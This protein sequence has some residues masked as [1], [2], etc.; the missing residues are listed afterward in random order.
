MASARD[1]IINKEHHDS[2]CGVSWAPCEVLSCRFPGTVPTD[3]IG[4]RG[5]IGASVAEVH[6]ISEVILT[7]ILGRPKDSLVPVE[8][9]A[10]PCVVEV[11]KA[12]LPGGY[13]FL[14]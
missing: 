7:V 4:R 9:F 1:T 8:S 13:T 11:R 3:S 10:W 5:A 12:L 6:L 14:G 2:V